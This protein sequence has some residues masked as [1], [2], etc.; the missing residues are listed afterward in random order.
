M[1]RMEVMVVLAVFCF[2]TAMVTVGTVSAQAAEMNLVD[3]KWETTMEVSMEGM[4]T[5]MPPMKTTQCITKKNAVPGDSEK[6][7]N[8][9]KV[10]EQKISGNT[11]SWKVKCDNQGMTTL[12]D[13]EVTYNGTTYK[14]NMTT[15]MTGKDGKSQTTKVKMAGKRIGDCK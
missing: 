9:C 13:G 7:H 2:L 11:V 5:K 4:P 6:Q 14:G 10:I 1:K 3:G 15:K 12:S 8:N